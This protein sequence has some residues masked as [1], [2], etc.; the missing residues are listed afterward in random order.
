MFDVTRQSIFNWRKKEQA[1]LPFYKLGGNG[2]SDPTRY[3]LDAVRKF[4]EASG[5]V[6][7]NDI[8]LAYT[9][10]ASIAA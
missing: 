6:I 5:K 7:V 3:S 9:T 1:C 4:A 8:Y 2:L 10:A